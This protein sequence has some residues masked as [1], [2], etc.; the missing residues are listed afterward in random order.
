VGAEGYSLPPIGFFWQGRYAL[1]ILV[2]VPI[3]AGHLVARAGARVEGLERLVPIAVAVLGLAHLVALLQTVR[4]FAV[5]LD[6]PANPIT[7]L[8]DPKWSP[9]TGPAVVWVVAFAAGLVATGW[10]SLRP[11]RLGR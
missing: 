4:R 5:T 11:A 9:D 2:G 7:Y 10:L 8:T 6:G 1:P 3:V